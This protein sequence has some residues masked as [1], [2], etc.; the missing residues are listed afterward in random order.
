MD[1]ERYF[2]EM[3][4]KVYDPLDL[5]PAIYGNGFMAGRHILVIEGC[6]VASSEHRV[7]LE[8]N[9]RISE[10][11][12]MKVVNID[13]PGLLTYGHIEGTQLG[14]DWVAPLDIHGNTIPTLGK[15]VDNIGSF[16]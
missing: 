1:A 15:K 7:K 13:D 10:G 3:D 14:T 4:T 2:E 9:P 11:M 8:N 5:A 12:I 16:K 6:V